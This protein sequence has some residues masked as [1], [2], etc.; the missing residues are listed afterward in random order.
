[1]YVCMYV[2]VCVC[3]ALYMYIYILYTAVCDSCQRPREHDG[4]AHDDSHLERLHVYSCM[5]VC[6]FTV[7]VIMDRESARMHVPREIYR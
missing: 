5:R 7:T 6:M 3:I 4:A 1:M 2:C